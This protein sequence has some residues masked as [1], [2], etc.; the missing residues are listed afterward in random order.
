MILLGSANALRA[1]EAGR[2]A[3]LAGAPALDVVERVIR[4]VE[5]DPDDHTVG[6]GGFPNILGEVELDA[7]LMEGATRRAGAVAALRGFRYPISVARE[8]MDRLPH[9]LL[10][11]DGAARFA[12]ECADAGRSAQPPEPPRQLEL[13]GGVSRR[14]VFPAR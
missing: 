1:F 12:D 5:D 7:S 13:R 14:P 2:T 9:V 3:L 10:V 4:E 11:G 6:Y 8:V